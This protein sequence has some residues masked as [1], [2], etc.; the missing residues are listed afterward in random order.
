MDEGAQRD[1]VRAASRADGR[2]IFVE[3]GGKLWPTN[4][5]ALE[6]F[7]LIKFFPPIFTDFH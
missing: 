2:Q 5:M 7:I 3:L 1:G 6:V 4:I